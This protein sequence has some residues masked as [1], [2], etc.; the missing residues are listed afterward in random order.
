[1]W[2]YTFAEEKL[3]LD[4]SLDNIAAM[5]DDTEFFRANRQFIVSREAIKDMS[6][7][8]GSRL[9][10]NLKVRP[11]EKIIISRAKV[12]EFKRWLSLR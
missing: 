1:M 8:F 11:P 4:K 12:P 7:W 5:L 2:A 9:S 10:L 6:V 3:P